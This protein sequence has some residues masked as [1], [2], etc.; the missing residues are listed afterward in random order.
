MEVNTMDHRADEKEALLNTRKALPCTG[1]LV[2]EKLSSYSSLLFTIRRIYC[3]ICLVV[4]WLRTH[5]TVQGCRFDPWSGSEDP[6][7]HRATKLSSHN[8]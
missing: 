7:C 6:T 3:R 5:W 4:Q 2:V 8:Y 1:S